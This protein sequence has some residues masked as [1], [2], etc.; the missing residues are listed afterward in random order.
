[1]YKY[2]FSRRDFLKTTAAGVLG[3]SAP[4]RALPSR[5]QTSGFFTVHP[6]IE[7]HPEAVFIMP[8]HVD[9]MLYDAAKKDAG[10]AFGRSVFVPGNEGGIPLDISIPVKMNLKTTGAGKFPLEDILGCV[11]D[12]FFAEGVFESIQEL[13]ISGNQIHLPVIQKIS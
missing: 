12:P 5:R 4:V 9:H 11:T 8:T 6:F 1:M 13:G 3:L 10:R 2:R 7:N